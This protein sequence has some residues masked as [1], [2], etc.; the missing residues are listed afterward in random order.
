MTLGHR[1]RR[2]LLGL[3]VIAAAVVALTLASVSGISRHI[4][5]QLCLPL[6][7][8]MAVLLGQLVSVHQN[9]RKHGPNYLEDVAPPSRKTLAA[10]IVAVVF[11]LAIGAMLALR[12]AP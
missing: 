10:A 2:L 8:F 3:A 6:L 4:T 11:V 12:V 1:R 9:I 7:P 5:L